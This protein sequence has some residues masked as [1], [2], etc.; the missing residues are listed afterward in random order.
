MT[1]PEIVTVSAALVG[2]VGQLAIALMASNRLSYFIGQQ[3]QRLND[4]GD[5]LS[6]VERE[7]A[8]H[9]RRISGQDVKIA[10][11]ETITAG[12]PRRREDQQ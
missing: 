8:D 5:R 10:R 12:M 9:N 11:L 1:P 7:S 2:I 4:H 6:K 3:T